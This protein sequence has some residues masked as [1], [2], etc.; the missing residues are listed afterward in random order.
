MERNDMVLDDSAIK[1]RKDLEKKLKLNKGQM[2]SYDPNVSQR[3]LSDKIIIMKYLNL[4]S[5]E[6]LNKLKMAFPINLIE[7]YWLRG[8]VYGGQNEPR[9]IHIA[10][11][12]FGIK[13][14]N[15]Y[16]ENKRANRLKKRTQRS[17]F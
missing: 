15:E 8:M 4:G 12:V 11:S 5:E 17:S 1:V 16:L 6:D 3:R 9:Q 13:R 10:K 7:R 14:P 2:W